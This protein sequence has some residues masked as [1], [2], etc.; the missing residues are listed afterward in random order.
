[1]ARPYKFLERKYKQFDRYQYEKRRYVQSDMFNA[2]IAY[3]DAIHNKGKQ[4]EK[5]LLDDYDNVVNGKQST[6]DYKAV[7]DST[8]QSS[9]LFK[10]SD[11]DP[12]AFAPPEMK[13]RLQNQKS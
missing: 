6:G 9:K 11:F 5:F 2:L 13:E 4:V 10:Q 1:M 12:F 3:R 8:T 7:Q